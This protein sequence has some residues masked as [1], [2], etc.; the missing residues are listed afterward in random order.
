LRKF[1]K[2]NDKLKEANLISGRLR[3]LVNAHFIGNAFV[4]IRSTITDPNAYDYITDFSKSLHYILSVST[5]SY[6]DNYVLLKDDIDFLKNYI[7]VNQK[8]YPN[9]EYIIDYGDNEE[10]LMEKVY[11]AILLPFIDNSIR[12]GIQPMKNFRGEIEIKYEKKEGFLECMIT[13]NGQ[14]RAKAQKMKEKRNS[15]NVDSDEFGIN[16]TRELLLF[17]FSHTKLKI[18]N[19]I[20]I[21]D[22]DRGTRIIVKMP[23]MLQEDYYEQKN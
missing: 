2:K 12:W 20:E 11:P 23:L 13:D 3:L 5:K 8:M 22:L 1:N 4:A 10:L 18:D 19:P 14:G 16:S 9:F 21:Q 15:K 6:K 17:L 7:K